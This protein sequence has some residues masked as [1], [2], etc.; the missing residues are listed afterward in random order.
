MRL[1]KFMAVAAAAVLSVSLTGCSGGSSSSA[2]EDTNADKGLPVVGS[3]LKYDP[4]KLVNDGKPITLEWWMW[5]GEDQFKGF[6][7]AYRKIHPNVDIKIVTHPWDDY[8]TKLPLA[9]KEGANPVLFN[10]HN[11]YHD[12]IINYL[13][14]YDIPVEELEADYQGAGA[15]VIDGKIYYTD[16][17]LMSGAIFYNK[18]MWAEAG[19]TDADIPQTWD[20]FREVAKKL[21]V[22]DGDNFQRAGFNFNDSFSAFMPGL[23][24]QRGQNLMQADMKT[25]DINNQA[26]LE[27]IKM[28]RDF[29]DVDKVGSKDFGPVANEAFGQGMAA[30][31]YSWG[32]FNNTLHTDYPDINFGVFR[33]PIHDAKT[34][35][36]AYD[37]YNGESTPGINAKASAA[38]KEVAQDFLRFFLTD[39]EH[40]K[41]ICL[42]Y[43]VFPMYKELSD[44]TDIKAHPVL[45]ALGSID[46]YIWPG[47]MPATIEKN[48]SKMW[49]DILHNGVSAQ[50]GLE[51]AQQAIA[52]DLSQTSFV[53]VEK[54][55]P[56]YKA[57]K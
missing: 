8:W 41:Q 28:F 39:K 10:I 52:T 46:R 43:S 38:E 54:L 12:N 21:T 24:Y 40:L 7:D 9:L 11:S 42:E 5:G 27:D 53:S 16:F 14:P 45:A 49:E 31:V 3:T 30:M 19:L 50:A 1:S 55:Y 37:R 34:E 36:Y 15:H 35:P 44:D 47:P 6:V 25:P 57:S 23:H 32:H 56:H 26:M 13:E 18:D 22:R 51:A 33:T 29:Y 2:V 48:L 17:G 20:Q 4:N